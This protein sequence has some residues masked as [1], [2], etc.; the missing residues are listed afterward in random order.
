MCRLRRQMR[1][2][3]GIRRR[4][5]RWRRRWRTSSSGC[6][7]RS[8]AASRTCWRRPSCRSGCRRRRA[9]PQRR[10]PPW[11]KPG[12]RRRPTRRARATR[13]ADARTPRRRH[14]PRRLAARCGLVQAAVCGT[15][16]MCLRLRHL[17]PHSSDCE[18]AAVDVRGVMLHGAAGVRGACLRVLPLPL[19]SR[20]VL[21]GTCMR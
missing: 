6:P 7:R 18:V 21:F 20:S 5:E 16:G 2:C 10:R 8:G 1:R 9:G 13:R 11:R 14:G 17:Q 3:R 15:R 4:S 12:A 19:H